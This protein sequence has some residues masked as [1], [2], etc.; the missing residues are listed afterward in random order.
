ME[1]SFLHLYL[2]VIQAKSTHSS[3][4]ALDFIVSVF[5]VSLEGWLNSIPIRLKE[6][7]VLTIT[8]QS[9]SDSFKMIKRD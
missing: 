4:Y 3:E 8:K 6:H 7:I 2:E 1:P 5:T 9:K